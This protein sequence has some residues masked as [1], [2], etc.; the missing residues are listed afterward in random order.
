MEILPPL[1]PPPAKEFVNAPNPPAASILPLP[2]IC[3]PVNFFR[4]ISGLFFAY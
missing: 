3:E 1:P 4:V 2:L